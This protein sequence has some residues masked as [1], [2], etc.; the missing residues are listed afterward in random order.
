MSEPVVPSWRPV[1]DEPQTV[2]GVDP[3]PDPG[4]VVLLCQGGRLHSATTTPRM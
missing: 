4:M 3:G 2:V 1:N